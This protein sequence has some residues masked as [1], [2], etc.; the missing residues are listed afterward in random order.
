MK[1]YKPFPETMS[2]LL[3]MEGI[4][5]REM[6]RRAVRKG[7]GVSQPHANRLRTGETEVSPEHMEAIARGLNIAPETFLE[8]RLWQVRRSY[9]PKEVGFKQATANLKRLERVEDDEDR[10]IPPAE[11]LGRDGDAPGGHAASA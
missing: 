2:M 1:S 5:V 3:D 4:G 9:D 6:H 7:W 10:E 11:L 8:Y